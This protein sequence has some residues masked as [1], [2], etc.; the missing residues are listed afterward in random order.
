MDIL[1]MEDLLPD[2][3]FLGRLLG[4][5]RELEKLAVELDGYRWKWQVR[6]AVDTLKLRLRTL[7][8]L[9]RSLLTY[10]GRAPDRSLALLISRHAT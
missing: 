10:V 1:T 5:G 8:T 6:A 3:P 7:D 2:E 4:I 9:G